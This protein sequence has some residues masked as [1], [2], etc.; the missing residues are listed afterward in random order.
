MAKNYWLQ[1]TQAIPLVS[2][3]SALINLLAELIELT[4]EMETGFSTGVL[5]IVYQAR[6]GFLA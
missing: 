4:E 3:T 5:H 2:E 1:E 6:A